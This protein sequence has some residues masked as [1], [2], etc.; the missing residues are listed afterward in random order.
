MRPWVRN[1]RVA[2]VL[3]LTAFA[4]S[5]LLLYDAY[6]RRGERPPFLLRLISPT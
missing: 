5:I 3:G 2:V 1:Q 6:D 4:V